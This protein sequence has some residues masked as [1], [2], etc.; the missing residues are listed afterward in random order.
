VTA[1]ELIAALGLRPHPEG[2]H[3]AE[4][5]RSDEAAGALPPRYVGPRALGTAIYYLLT[6][7]T[8][9]A[10]HRV[11]SDEVLHFYLGDP[12]ELLV[13]WP[14]G[15]GEVRVLGPD[16]AAGMR[17]QA[18][19]PRGCWQ[20][21][22]VRSGGQLALLGATVAPGFDYADFE[23]GARGPLTAAYPA[24]AELIRELTP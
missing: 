8:R 10:L 1:S 20:G 15:R 2:G 24:F 12:V 14:D 19:I 23:L 18:V 5:Y 6:A 13:L 3:F 16:V 7:G 4:T 11:Q 21:A 17:P 22:R 9:S